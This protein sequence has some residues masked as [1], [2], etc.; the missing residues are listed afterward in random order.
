MNTFQQT[1]E[2]H[3]RNNF[4]DRVR[5]ATPQ[6]PRDGAWAGGVCAG[7][8]DR[9]GRHVG[10][11][12]ALTIVLALF[13]GLG[14]LLY[15][16]AWLILPAQSGRIHTQDLLIGQF[17]GG[18]VAGLT[19]TI[20]GLCSPAFWTGLGAAIVAGLV[21]WFLV[22]TSRPAADQRSTGV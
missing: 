18:G 8:A 21:V 1:H 6:R 4:F 20:V 12:R 14:V 7:L 10:V 17:T 2:T 16:L 13:G 11:V 19:V 3:H 22:A 9:L 5:R 15:G